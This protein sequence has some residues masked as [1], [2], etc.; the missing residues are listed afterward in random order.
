METK[1]QYILGVACLK[2]NLALEEVGQIL[3][4]KLFGGIPFGGKDKYIHEEVPAI[5]ISQT[6]MG[7][8]I[9]LDG[10]SGLESGMG[11]NLNITSL[12]VP[13]NVAYE[14]IRLD[15]YLTQLLKIQ[16]SDRDDIVV[17]D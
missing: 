14:D 10:H 1:F 12:I 4:E 2:S 16:L 5:F 11:F 13:D 8:R 17:I 15:N 9:V 7:L 3:S 6:V